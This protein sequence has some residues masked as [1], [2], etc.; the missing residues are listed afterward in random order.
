MIGIS[1]NRKTLFCDFVSVFWIRPPIILVSPSLSDNTVSRF[2]VPIVTT[3]VFLSEPTVSLLVIELTSRPSF[4]FISLF[5]WIVGSA[6]TLTP[7]STYWTFTLNEPVP[8]EEV[9]VIGTL[10]PTL[11]LAFSRFLTRI[12]GF[13]RV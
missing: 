1:P 9:V 4:I 2:R 10:V 3:V 12:L 5:S 7:T 11:N 13:D 8:L 6:F